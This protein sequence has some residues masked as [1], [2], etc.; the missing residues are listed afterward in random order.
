MEQAKFNNQKKDF[1]RYFDIKQ[2]YESFNVRISKVE[3]GLKEK[4]GK[5]SE[6][7]QMFKL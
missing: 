1:K 7:I 6:M 5:H 2:L 3:M 4:E